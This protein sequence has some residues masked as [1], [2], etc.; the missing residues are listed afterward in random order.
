MVTVMVAVVATVMMIV[1]SV[2]DVADNCC[3]LFLLLLLLLVYFLCFACCCLT[4]DDDDGD[5]LT[6]VVIINA[7]GGDASFLLFPPRLTATT[8]FTPFVHPSP[9]TIPY[10]DGTLREE[11]SRFDPC[12]ATRGWKTTSW[13]ALLKFPPT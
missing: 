4:D 1:M 10:D 9:A 5:D 6:G 3:L 11:Q 8:S 13:W 2:D 12:Q 7:V